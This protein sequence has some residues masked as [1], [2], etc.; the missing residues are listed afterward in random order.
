MGFWR[1]GAVLGVRHLQLWTVLALVTL[2]T[3][4]GAQGE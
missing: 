1:A 4:G 3:L 2:A